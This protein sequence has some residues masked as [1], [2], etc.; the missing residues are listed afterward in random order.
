MKIKHNTLPVLGAG[1][2]ASGGNTHFNTTSIFNSNPTFNFNMNGPSSVAVN[3]STNPTTNITTTTNNSNANNQTEVSGSMTSSFVDSR[4]M[5][6][7]INEDSLSPS[8]S[9][10]IQTRSK[11]AQQHS[12]RH[13]QTLNASNSL[14]GGAIKA[15]CA[16]STTT[17][18]D[19]S[20]SFKRHSHSHHNHNQSQHSIGKIVKPIPVRPVSSSSSSSTHSSFG[21][22]D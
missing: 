20:S 15:S 13:H 22:G 11:A 21:I 1:S 16:T 10:Q 19:P 18:T 4:S 14:S 6:A 17:T 9:T 2:G 12:Q 8:F 7:R 3:F 5:L